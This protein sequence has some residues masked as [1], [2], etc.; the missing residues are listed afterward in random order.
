MTEEEKF[1]YWIELAQYDLD[2]AAAM[3]STG[4]WF[5]VVFMCQQAIEKYCKGLYTLYIDDSV[6]KIHNIKTIFPVSRRKYR[7]PS[8]TKRSVFLIP[9]LPNISLT[10]ILILAIYRDNIPAKTKRKQFWQE[11]GRCLHGC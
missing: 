4:R 3:F 8:M 9:F 11:P 2:T 5:Y 1:N 7:P 6:P 10:G